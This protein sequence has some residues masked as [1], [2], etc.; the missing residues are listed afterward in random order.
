MA[1]LELIDR[2]IRLAELAKDAPDDVRR[3]LV[4]TLTWIN[5]PAVLTVPLGAAT[6]EGIEAYAAAKAA[7]RA[8]RLEEEIARHRKGSLKDGITKFFSRRWRR[9]PL[10][11]G[12]VTAC[13][14]EPAGSRVMPFTEE[15]GVD[16]AARH[17]GPPPP[18][19]VSLG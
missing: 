16:G 17:G 4:L 11:E 12:L 14:E 10:A 2:I 3:Q 19:P 7:I 1:D 5:C 13:P 18:P 6:S 15:Q 8:A 9:D